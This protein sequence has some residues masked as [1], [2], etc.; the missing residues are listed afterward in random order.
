[1]HARALAAKAAAAGAQ[2]WLLS[3][4]GMAEVLNW[5]ARPPLVADCDRM[6]VLASWG[7]HCGGRAPCQRL[8]PFAAVRSMSPDDFVRTLALDLKARIA[9]ESNTR[10]PHATFHHSPDIQSVAMEL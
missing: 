5:P 10:T 7:P 3:F 9:G 8:I 2:P 6:R 4:S 1:M